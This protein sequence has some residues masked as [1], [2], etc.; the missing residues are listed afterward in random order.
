[1]GIQL[2]ERNLRAGFM[3]GS[4]ASIERRSQ[5]ALCAL[6]NSGLLACRFELFVERA[7]AL[8]LRDEI[9]PR[10]LDFVFEGPRAHWRNEPAPKQLGQPEQ[11]SS[12]DIVTC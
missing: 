10:L 1:M 7:D 9:G 6:K 8:V 4:I 12:Y 5:L 3:E 2:E 11:R